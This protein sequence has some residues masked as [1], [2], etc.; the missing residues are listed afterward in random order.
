MSMPW[1][2]DL[3]VS[4]ALAKLRGSNALPASP[5]EGAKWSFKVGAAIIALPNFSWRRCAID[6]HDLHHVLINQPCNLKGETQVATWEFAAGAYP[7]IWPQL[8]CLPLVAAGLVISPVGAW[9][10]FKNGRRQRSL[11]GIA[12][13]GAMRLGDL[14][15]YINNRSRSRTSAATDWW[16]F[17]LLVSAPFA[18]ALI[19][20]AFALAFLR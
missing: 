13:D 2:D 9:R 20:A 5:D 8:F 1:S 17:L 14:R 3:S 11:Y 7:S 6:R 10:T 16:R 18:L 4:D 15:G 12:I 19:P